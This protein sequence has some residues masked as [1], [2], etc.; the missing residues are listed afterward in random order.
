MPL[1]NLTLATLRKAEFGFLGLTVKTLTQT[2]LLSGDAFLTGLFFKALKL[3][4]K[5]GRFDFFF[6]VFL[7]FL[8]N[9]LIVGIL[10]CL[11]TKI[12]CVNTLFK[13]SKQKN[14]SQTKLNSLVSLKPDD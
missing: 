11:K 10:A 8:I 7:G 1:L 3:N 4:V 14:K 5:A 12:S 9:W 13:V 6:G 2:P